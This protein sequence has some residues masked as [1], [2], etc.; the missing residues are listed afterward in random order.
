M[1]RAID[2]GN[3]L[4]LILG[5]M[6][7]MVAT[8]VGV[9]AVWLVVG[10]GAVAVML[11]VKHSRMLNGCLETCEQLAT[12]EAKSG[13]ELRQVVSAPLI[14][15][16]MGFLAKAFGVAAVWGVLVVAGIIRSL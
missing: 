4:T 11:Q 16:A 1:A 9:E 8:V 13:G 12:S 14:A 2:G 10:F 3:M 5:L 15:L 6:M 7:G